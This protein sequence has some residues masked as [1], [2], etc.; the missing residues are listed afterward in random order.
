MPSLNSAWTRQIL[1]GGYVQENRDDTPVCIRLQ[2]VSTGSVTSVTTIAATNL[3]TVTA[4][5]SGTTTKTYTFATYTTIGSLVDAI[6]ADGLFTATT[7]DALRSDSTTSSQ[8]VGAT[9]S[10]TTDGSGVTIWNLT[11]DTSV[12]KALT[13]AAMFSRDVYTNTLNKGHRVSLQEISYYADVNA[14][15]ANAVRVY[16]RRG[17]VETQVF[18]HVSVDATVTTISFASG[19][20][21]ITGR[22]GDILIVRVQDATSLTDSTSN[23]IRATYI[24]E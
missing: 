21:K 7:M 8:I 20:G 18:G 1:A 4:E 23:Y 6:N 16:I 17:T 19:N 14:A 9:I 3:I 12:L 2:Y 24:S 11:N 22:D 13:A 5:T 10:S 15:S